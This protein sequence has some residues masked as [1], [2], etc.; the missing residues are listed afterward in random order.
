MRI[1]EPI[2]TSID[3]HAVCEPQDDGTILVHTKGLDQYGMQEL[4]IAAENI[5]AFPEAAEFIRRVVGL[6]LRGGTLL[7]VALSVKL[8][9]SGPGLFRL[10]QNGDGSILITR[11]GENQ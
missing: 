2:I 10:S 4:V 7:S 1:P 6:A 9:D 8:Q 3:W 11:T 5:D